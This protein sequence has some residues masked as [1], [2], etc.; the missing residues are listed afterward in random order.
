MTGDWENILKNQ[1]F[2]IQRSDLHEKSEK[3]FVSCLGPEPNKIKLDKII[4]KKFEIV[5]FSTNAKLYEFPIL[6]FLKNKSEKDKFYAW[7]I[8]AKGVIS[9]RKNKIIKYWRHHLEYF[10]INKYENCVKTL[11]DG[12]DCCGIWQDD[13]TQLPNV[14]HFSGNFWWANSKYIKK[15][16]YFSEEEKSNRWK[17]LEWFDKVK[18]N[19]KSLSKA[20]LDHRKCVNTI[21]I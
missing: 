13:I 4:P 19:Y 3:I 11:N 21:K 2:K 18:P 9:G 15:L 6:E 20:Y 5:L 12:Y 14:E 7:Y 1:I 17:V 10:I 8:H 16:P